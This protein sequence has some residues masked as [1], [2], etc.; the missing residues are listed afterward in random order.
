VKFLR[1]AAAFMRGCEIRPEK[2]WTQFCQVAA[3]DQVSC[4]IPFFCRGIYAVDA[5]SVL[6]GWTQFCQVAL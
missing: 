1:F 6:K 5:K 2:G 4:E 3:L